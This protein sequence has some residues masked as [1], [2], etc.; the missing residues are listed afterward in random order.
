MAA[1]LDAAVAGATVA[2]LA[3]L[4]LLSRD[5]S[6]W[7]FLFLVITLRR[8]RYHEHSIERRGMHG[9]NRYSRQDRPGQKA[10]LLRSTSDFF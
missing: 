10:A 7:L 3:A 5:H 2:L 8:L 4:A 9:S 1:A 6:C